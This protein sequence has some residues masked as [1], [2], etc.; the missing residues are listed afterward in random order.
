MKRND[1]LAELMAEAPEVFEIAPGLSASEMR[2]VYFD[3]D[4]LREPPYRL[5]RLDEQGYRYYYRYMEVD[6]KQKA[7]LYPSVTTLLRQTTP[8]SP[9][10][11]Q[12]MV[13]NGSAATEKRD[14]AAAYGTFMHIQFERLLILRQID[15]DK[16]AAVLRD[17]MEQENIP[18]KYYFE[19]LPRIRKDILAFAQFVQDYKVKPLAVEISL[20]S[21]LGFA[22]CIDLPCEMTIK[23]ETFSAIIDFKSGRNGF[24]EDYELQLGLYRDMW[25]ENF[26]DCPIHRIFNFAPKDWRK[27]PTYTL[28]EQTEAASLAMLPHLIEIAKI[29]DDKRD[30]DVTYC[31]GI[32]NLDGDLSGHFH[33]IS[34]CELL[35][36]K[37]A[38]EQE[39]ETPEA[40][41]EAETLFDAE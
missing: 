9:F 5:F 23:D 41:P 26:P 6:G 29:K 11:I 17:Y 16:M 30:K 36:T 2:A 10:L 19:W 13:E 24:Y 40:K 1:P 3:F 32:V 8:T 15:L 33:T 22:G 7:V 14:M 25:N 35:T 12:W 37:H 39:V 20:V 21:E 31:D 28:K 38:G 4:A 27:S 34:L 18:D